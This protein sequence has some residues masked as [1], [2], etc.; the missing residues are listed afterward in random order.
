MLDGNS[1]VVRKLEVINTMSRLQQLLG[2]W[3]SVPAKLD[4]AMVVCLVCLH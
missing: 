3:G 4:V 1:L 2:Q